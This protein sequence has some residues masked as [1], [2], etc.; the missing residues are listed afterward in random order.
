ME[1]PVIGVEIEA[2]KIYSGKVRELFE[3][4]NG[5][6]LLVATDRVSAFDFI[7]PTPIPGK[8][9]ILT[10][11]S[12]FW[13]DYLGDT[14]EN[15]LV[16]RDF[17][18]FPSF[19][20]KHDFL[21]GRSIIVKKAERLPLECV[22][23]GYLSGSGWAEYMEKGEICGVPLPEN[24]KEG[25][26]I[27]DPVFTPAT[28]EEAGRHDM[29]ITFEEA[30]GIVGPQ[31]AAL[32]KNI[33]LKIYSKAS[34]Y[35]RQKGIIIADTKF[36]FGMYGNRLIIIDELLTPDSSR[37]WEAEKYSEGQPRESLDK[38]YIR[39]YLLSTGWDRK[40]LPPALPEEVVCQTIS[41]YRQIYRQLTGKPI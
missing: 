5:N 25:S 23:R 7:L 18:R 1:E 16:E 11:M 17:E 39:N 9:I 38:Q 36:E 2:K 15:H 35:A 14:I 32:L 31:K 10:Q 24:L 13:F 26:K 30:S 4:D 3:L 28:K 29:N 6:I 21:R 34:E 27:P 22:V 33:S 41:K 37:F 12:L 19:L 40:S 20:K 8:G